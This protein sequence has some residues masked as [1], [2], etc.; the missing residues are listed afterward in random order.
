MQ[1]I[2][3]IGTGIMGKSMVGHLV[4][5]G[6]EVKVFTRTQEKAREAIEGGATWCDTPREAAAGSDVVVSIVG[7]PDDVREVVFGNNGVAGVLGKG[8][9][10]IDMTTSTPSLAEEIFAEGELR[11]WDAIDAPVSGG[12]IGAKAASLTIFCGGMKTA[13]D[14]VTPVLSKMGTNITHAGPAGK[15]QHLKMCN[16]ILVC[17]TILGVCESLHY[18]THAGLDLHQTIAAIEKGAAGGYQISNLGPKTASRDFAPGFYIDHFV[19][20]LGIAVDEAT[21]MNLTLPGLHLARDLYTTMQRL[22]HGQKGTQALILALE[23]TKNA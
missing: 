7:T 15:G 13:V 1:K 19:K 18:A 2:G 14:K 12:D 11:G 20:D 6:H 9:T 4:K 23:H 16:Q 17:S 10:F 22:G 8:Q 3:W 21:R 5:A